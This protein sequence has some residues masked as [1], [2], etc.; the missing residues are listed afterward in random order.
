MDTVELVAFSQLFGWSSL[1]IVGRKIKLFGHV[2]N[3]YFSTHKE[4]KYVQNYTS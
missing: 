3:C 4:E 1:P 2:F